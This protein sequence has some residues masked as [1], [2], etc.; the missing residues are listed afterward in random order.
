[1]YVVADIWCLLCVLAQLSIHVMC[2]FCVLHNFADKSDISNCS[3][4]GVAGRQVIILAGGWYLP[5]WAPSVVFM[6]VSVCL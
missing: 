3:E 1:M 6:R 5:E 2:V 4:S